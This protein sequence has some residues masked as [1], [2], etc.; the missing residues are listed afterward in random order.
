MDF[1]YLGRQVPVQRQ[2][3]ALTAEIR[4]SLKILQMPFPEVLKAVEEAVETNPVLEYEDRSAEDGEEAVP[5]N[6][7]ANPEGSGA[8]TWESLDFPLYARASSPELPGGE[9]EAYVGEPASRNAFADD[10]L[11]QL[12]ALRIAPSLFGVCRHIVACLDE[13]GY[14]ACSPDEIAKSAAIPVSRVRQAL[15]AVQQLEPAGVGAA[16]LRECLILQLRRKPGHNPV[17]LKIAEQDLTLVAKNKINAIARTFH[18]TAAEAQRCCGEI[19]GLN[20]I[21]ANGYDTGGRTAFTVPEAEVR[22]DRD[23]G[24]VVRYYSCLR[25]GLRISPYY[26]HLAK[27]ADCRCTE[28]YLNGKMKEASAFLRQIAYRER[29]ISRILETVIELQRPCFLHGMSRLTPMSTGDIAKKLGLNESTV[30]RAVRGKYILYPFGAVALKAFFTSGIGSRSD[31]KASSFSVKATIRSL[32][33]LEAKERPLS[34]QQIC[35]LLNRQGLEISR[36]TVAKYRGEMMIPSAEK[37][38]IYL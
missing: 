11:E 10:L 18:I 12:S 20:P 14:L 15:R 33:S 28:A 36:R 24:V 23:G 16:D 7:G 30:S 25:A 35:T 8:V 13:R 38:R 21:P 1:S 9:D 29:T 3:L 6:A 27:Q 4:E 19:R 31:G 37:R 2:K 32:I 22:I 17:T 5:D 26:R 34:D